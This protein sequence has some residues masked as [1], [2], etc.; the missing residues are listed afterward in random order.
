MVSFVKT[1]NS[2]L[3]PEATNGISDPLRDG[4]TFAGWRTQTEAGETV[5]SSDQLKDVPDGTALTA[6]W[7]E[8]EPEPEPPVEEEQA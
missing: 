2:L 6:V 8:G 5:Y 1:E 4:Y 3:N 7:T